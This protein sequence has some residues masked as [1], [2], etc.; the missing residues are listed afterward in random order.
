MELDTCS[1]LKRDM[2]GARTA[3]EEVSAERLLSGPEYM[4]SEDRRLGASQQVFVRP[5]GTFQ[6]KA[7]TTCPRGRCPIACI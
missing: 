3:L 6:W 4:P 2:R 5:Q 1:V 7:G